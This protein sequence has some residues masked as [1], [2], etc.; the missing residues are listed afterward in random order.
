MITFRP[1][2]G[3]SDERVTRRIVAIKDGVATTQADTTGST[4]PWAVP[5]TSASYPRVWL[6]VP[7]IGYPFVMDGG[8]VLLAAAAL[9]ALVL[10]LTTGRRTPQKV[11]G[12]TR[13]HLPVG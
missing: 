4:D 1:P 13:T 2:D 3:S 6:G 5:L 10:A 9:A 11:V 12:H 7:W 8:W